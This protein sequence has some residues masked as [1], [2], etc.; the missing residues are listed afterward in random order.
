MITA[1]LETPEGTQLSA[2]YDHDGHDSDAL[3][4]ALH[5]WAGGVGV[6]QESIDRLGHGSFPTPSFRTGRTITLRM[7]FE[8]DTREDLFQLERDCSGLFHDG[9]YGELT[10]VADAQEL[11][12]DVCLDG[13]VK[14]VV[15]LDGGYIEVE[16]P[17][18]SADP[19]LYAPEQVSFLHPL[20]TGIGLEYPL[21]HR[22]GVLTFGTG[23]AAD[24]PI[25]N[26]GNAEAW[27]VFLVVGDF[28]G[29]F[30]ITVNGRVITWPWPTTKSRPVEVRMD[31]AI[32]EAGS[33]M[34]HRASRR[35]W[36]SIPP[37]GV[38]APEFRA[39]QGGEGWCEV[40]HRNTYI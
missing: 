19:F 30:E 23:V 25:R 38:I 34:T 15:H 39:L 18:K 37:G 12:C 40:H 8:R 13:D 22:G 20:G 21:F 16:I 11:S 10:V 2:Q 24:D 26:E 17:L 3:L 29:G 5:G 28:P 31:G 27:P 4:V 36:V 35:D 1:I 32:F 6:R 9:G 7:V 33:N 14:P